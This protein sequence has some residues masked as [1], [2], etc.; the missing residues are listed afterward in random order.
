MLDPGSFQSLPKL[1]T[2]ERHAVVFDMSRA[3]DQGFSALV[4][5]LEI[6]WDFQN[7]EN[8]CVIGH[9]FQLHNKEGRY[10]WLNEELRNKAIEVGSIISCR[11]PTEK[12]YYSG[13]TE[14]KLET[15]KVLSHLCFSNENAKSCA[16]AYCGL[17]EA[18]PN[19]VISQR[20]GVYQDTTRPNP[21]HALICISSA[22]IVDGRIQAITLLNEEMNL[23]NRS[24]S[25]TQTSIEPRALAVEN[26]SSD[27]AIGAVILVGFG[28]NPT[29]CGKYHAL[30]EGI[31][32][33]SAQENPELQSYKM[34]SCPLGKCVII[35][36]ANFQGE[37]HTR[38]GTEHDEKSLRDLFE[39]LGFA[40]KIEK[41]LT[42]EEIH[43]VSRDATAEDHSKF[44]VFAFIILS[45]GGKGDVVFGVDDRPV[46]IEDIMREF[47]AINCVTLRGKPK[48]FF[49]QSCRGSSSEFLSPGATNHHCDSRLPRSTCDSTL[50]RNL[51]P[52]ECDFLLSFAAA[53]DYFAYRQPEYG[54]V[55]IQVLVD[56]IRAHHQHRH[57]TEMLNEVTAKVVEQGSTEGDK[58]PSVQVP[59]YSTSLRG[60]VYL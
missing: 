17:A 36:N 9:P 38:N 29:A 50:A 15:N 53:P 32:I 45:H 8:A 26:L 5:C 18:F 48:L 20:K 2:L 51:C 7:V 10:I 35:N 49:I 23:S 12:W 58:M 30:C 34:N 59:T 41:D 57:L 55:Y 31:L 14:K 16:V 39:E 40:V 60:N 3:H 52:Q 1:N 56:V 22:C 19:A 54:S 46:R 11:K 4:F 42:W 47:K 25:H 33:N 44:D 6:V 24:F 43:K 37:T 21:P 27:G 28:F 13:N